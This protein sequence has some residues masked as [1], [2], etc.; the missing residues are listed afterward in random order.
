MGTIFTILETST[1]FGPRALQFDILGQP[2]FVMGAALAR[3]SIG[4]FFARMLGSTA[5]TWRIVLYVVV[6]LLAII[7]LVFSL[8]LEVQCMPLQRLWDPR[9]K[10]TCWSQSARMDL[11]YVQGSFAVVS[12]FFLAMAPLLLRKELNVVGNKRWPLIAFA[13][14]S[15]W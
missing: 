14:L 9:V 10:G 1:P 8:L 15:V 11:D 13:A 12:T 2:W 6:A 5:P 3:I 4:L 7:D